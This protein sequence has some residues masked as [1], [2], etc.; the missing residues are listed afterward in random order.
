ML[1]N[2]NPSLDQPRR[3]GRAAR[4]TAALLSDRNR[5]P[6]ESDHNIIACFTCG[7]TFIC[8]GRAGELNGRFCSMPCQDWHDAGRP[9]VL[10]STAQISRADG[11]PVADW[12]VVVGPRNLVLGASYYAPSWPPKASAAANRPLASPAI[13]PT[14][15]GGRQPTACR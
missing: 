2:P 1:F 9:S 8:V 3:G 10:N 11:V 6:V 15:G 12:K 5:E 14:S 4:L 13:G 7:H